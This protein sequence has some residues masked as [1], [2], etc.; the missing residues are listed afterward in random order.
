MKLRLLLYLLKAQ[1]KLGVLQ[2][3]LARPVLQVHLLP[4]PRAALAQQVALDLPAAVALPARQAQRVLLVAT[5]Q[6]ATARLCWRSINGP[7]QRQLLFQAAHQPTLGQMP[8]SQIRLLMVGRKHRL[9]VL[10]VRLYMDA[11][12][13][14]RTN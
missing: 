7:H 2:E 4:D 8:H 9:L 1:H 3:L 6:T 12:K 13:L 14:I 11:L 10:R 5:V